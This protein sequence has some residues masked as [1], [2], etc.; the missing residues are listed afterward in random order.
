MGLAALVSLVGLMGSA[1]GSGAL[2]FSLS[3]ATSAEVIICEQRRDA[4]L[5]RTV[6]NP[7]ASDRLINN[8]SFVHELDQSLLC[9][10][11]VDQA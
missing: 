6:A 1:V 10:Y 7:A 8:R 5:I 11:L 4:E 3:S 9:A 2:Q